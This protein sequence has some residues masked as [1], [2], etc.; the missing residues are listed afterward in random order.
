MAPRIT[1][2]VFLLCLA[3]AFSSILARPSAAFGDKLNHG[4]RRSVDLEERYDDDDDDGD[5]DDK[6]DDDDDRRSDD[7]KESFNANDDD[8]DDDDDNDDD[9]R[10][11]LF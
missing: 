3:A 11:C 1:V 8:D 7:L 10:R 5:G 2:F 4:D 9:D 6:H